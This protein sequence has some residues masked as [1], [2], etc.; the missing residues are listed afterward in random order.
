MKI[1]GCIG[2]LI[3]VF[4]AGAFTSIW[5]DWGNDVVVAR[6]ENE[7]GKLIRSA[8]YYISSC[9]SNTEITVK[10]I[11]PGERKKVFFYVCGEGEYYL[12]SKFSDGPEV[13][14][15]GGYIESGYD[16]EDTVI[17]SGVKT[18]INIIGY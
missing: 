16:I 15:D 6:L 9:N 1:Y 5:R 7:S 14:G 4:L 13:R 11:K 10:N 12:L 8:T 17:Q 3:I 18:D 2:L